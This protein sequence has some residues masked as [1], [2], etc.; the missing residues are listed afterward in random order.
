M[1]V[2]ALID[3]NNHASMAGDEGIHFIF[4]GSCSAFPASPIFTDDAQMDNVRYTYE[5]KIP[6]KTFEAQTCHLVAVDAVGNQQA[7]SDTTQI[8]VPITG[9]RSG[10][11][12]GGGGGYTPIASFFSSGSSSDDSTTQDDPVV[13]QRVVVE[14]QPPAEQ[15]TRTF[16]RNLGA[17]DIGDD[18]RR[19]QVFLNQNGFTI[20]DTGPGSPGSETTYYGSLT[21]QAVARYQQANG[22]QPAVG[23]FGP[24]T[25]AHVNSALAITGTTAGGATTEDDTT[26]TYVAPDPIPQPFVRSQ[27]QRGSAPSFG[28]PNPNVYS[29]TQQI[30]SF[31][32]PSEL[33]APLFTAPTPRVYSHTQQAPVE[34]EE[35]D[36]EPYQE[37]RQPSQPIPLWGAV[38]G[39]FTLQTTQPRAP[40]APSL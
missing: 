27:R 9:T 33:E 18:V 36:E 2:S 16:T 24:I 3:R 39:P 13:E 14:Q 11:G 7:E 37:P 28:P 32:V 10:G 34:P 6:R 25:R 20:A 4:T 8:Y 17:G 23:S 29:Y 31:P 26:T 21:T 35:E 40:F 12:G 19:L 30:P 22:I 1:T 5:I 15:Q 38:G